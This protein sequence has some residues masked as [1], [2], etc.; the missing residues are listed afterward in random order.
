M[1]TKGIGTM[2]KLVIAITVLT[3]I[4]M[5]ARL[6]GFL[7]N[8]TTTP[9]SQNTPTP[10]ISALPTNISSDSDIDALDA[11]LDKQTGEIDRLDKDLNDLDSSL[12]TTDTDQSMKELDAIK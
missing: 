5:V 9:Q 2:L 4:A 3:L 12:S 7:G 10:S 11:E 8:P 6:S 1:D